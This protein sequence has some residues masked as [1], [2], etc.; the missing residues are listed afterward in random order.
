MVVISTGCGP[1]RP[2]RIIPPPLDP[3]AV[4]AAVAAA[5]PLEKLPAIA[6][7]LKVFDTNKDQQVSSEELVT[8]LEEVR[9]SQVAITSVMVQVT[10][11]GTPL[12]GASVKLVPEAS[13]G[14]AIQEAAGSSDASGI[15]MIT[16]T[17]SMY[18]GVNC[19]LY[20]VEISGNGNDGKPLPTKYNAETTL[21]MAVGGMLPENGIAIFNLK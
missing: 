15:A 20:R 9:A 6:F 12:A 8:W 11:K 19:G 14:G 3:A 17:G 16:I 10:H 5:G 18:P 13:M 1:S 7:S 4:A 21:G 2:A